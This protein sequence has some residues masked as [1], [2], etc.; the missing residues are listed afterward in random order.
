MPTGDDQGRVESEIQEILARTASDG[1]T[2]A[3]QGAREPLDRELRNIKETVIRMGSMAEAAIRDALD[4]LVTHNAEKATAVVIGDRKINDMQH[5]V[6]TAITTTIATQGPVARDLRN[7]LMMN[8]VAYE[9]ERIG[10]HAASVAKI[11]IQLA[12]EPA[13]QR[14]L[15][16]P[17]IGELAATQLH[18]ILMALVDV[19]PVRAREVAV[20]DDQIDALYRQSFDE[21]IRLMEADKS[22]VA[23]GTRLLFAAH[24]LE[25]IGDRTTNI[26]EDIV[27]LASGEVEDLNP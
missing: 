23:R 8:H 19:D 1:A 22:N 6:I 12:P 3:P 27:Y 20:S 24:Y 11:A 26:A 4:A 21:C 10:D 16:L 17:E 14:Y 18:G 25:R 2:A 13:L 9:L 15:H 7:L 5:E